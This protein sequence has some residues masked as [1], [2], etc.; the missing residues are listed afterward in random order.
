MNMPFLSRHK[1]QQEQVLIKSFFGVAESQRSAPAVDKTRVQKKKTLHSGAGD[2][3]TADSSHTHDSKTEALTGSQLDFESTSVAS[4]TE[5]PLQED[6]YAK[7]DV[8]DLSQLIRNYMS[9]HEQGLEIPLTA[10]QDTEKA[11]E[12]D[13]KTEKIDDDDQSQSSRSTVSLLSMEDPAYVRIYDHRGRIR[14]DVRQAPTSFK[15][16]RKIAFY[17]RESSPPSALVEI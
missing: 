4:F 7:A 16:P 17:Q 15:L 11:M 14:K 13:Q 10:K 9:R 1:R 8:E 2:L 12:K 6:V 3:L 5:F